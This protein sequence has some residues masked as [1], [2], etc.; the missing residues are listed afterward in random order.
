M[1]LVDKI[2]KKQ[3]KQ[4]KALS[5]SYLIISAK[6][7][8]YYLVLF[9]LRPDFKIYSVFHIS[10]STFFPAIKYLLF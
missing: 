3:K 9:F 2:A 10:F 4:T 7:L 5:V 6:H 1:N 8:T